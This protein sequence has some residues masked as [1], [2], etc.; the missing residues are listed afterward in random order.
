MGLLS[1]LRGDKSKENA[2]KGEAAGGKG[3]R[4]SNGAVSDALRRL[5]GSPA[6]IA[7]ARRVV[8]STQLS[9]AE[10][11]EAYRRINSSVTY[12]NQRDNG[13]DGDVMCNMTSMAMA[14]N[15]L[16]MGA[17]ESKS[18]QYENVLD[19]KRSGLGLSRYD[20][21]QRESLAE[22]MGLDAIT[23]R[24][25]AFSDGP[26]AKAWYLENVY[27]RMAA[28]ST[29]TF[30]V[31][32]GNGSGGTFR[33]VIRLE[34]VEDKGLRIDDPFGAGVQADEA[35]TAGYTKLN[36]KQGQGGVGENGLL[37][38]EQVA[39]L[40]KSRYVQL[41]AAKGQP[42]A[43]PAGASK[44]PPTGAPAAPSPSPSRPSGSSGRR[45]GPRR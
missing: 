34:W 14:F 21:K 45:S 43:P 10:R 16:G 24:T 36:D 13:S 12:R 2:P 35:G 1:W 19:K 11:A 20:E 5:D 41:Y 30:G 8:G 32:G 29:A 3:G 7:E 38:W 40:N 23:L 26:S 4:I 39:R 6:S 42:K 27:P 9:N 15:G 31:A 28:G 17:D 37:T 44:A 25:P 22:G 33:H 18:G